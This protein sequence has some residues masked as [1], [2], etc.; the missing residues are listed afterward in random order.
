MLD[1]H[2][3]YGNLGICFGTVMYPVGQLPYISCNAGNVHV[4][5]ISAGQA[6]VTQMYFLYIK[7]N[8]KPSAYQSDYL[9]VCSSRFGWASLNDSVVLSM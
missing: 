5:A 2:A 7:S 9:N 4:A 1:T 6:S 3:I 8:P